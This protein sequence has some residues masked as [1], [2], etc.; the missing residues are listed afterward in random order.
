[1]STGKFETDVSEILARVGE[2]IGSQK[3]QEIGE[4]LGVAPQTISMW[5]TRKHL[6]IDNICQFAIER[7]A[8]L[9]YLILGKKRFDRYD[10]TQY[11][12]ALSGNVDSLLDKP[13][14]YIDTLNAALATKN[15]TVVS[16]VLMS[17]ADL[18]ER[19]GHDQK[20]TGSDKDGDIN[21]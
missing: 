15:P 2:I 18:I 4:A 17:M 7:Q 10:I 20:R 5:R 11:P 21:K 9:D 3:N 12:Y 1:M 16:S 19:K 14:E 8:S 6:A 13:R